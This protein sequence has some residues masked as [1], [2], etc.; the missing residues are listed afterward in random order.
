MTNHHA[1]VKELA[2]D[3]TAQYQIP[4]H[5]V[6]VRMLDDYV[7]QH[8]TDDLPA[9]WH[10]LVRITADVYTAAGMTVLP[11]DAEPPAA[12]RYAV[13]DHHARH[14]VVLCQVNQADAYPVIAAY[15]TQLSDNVEVQKGIV[16]CLA[17]LVSQTR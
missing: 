14:L 4:R 15:R 10:H 17:H 5:D 11:P 6:A 13:Y 2:E 7:G 9:V 8:G 12:D 3:L 16:L 1:R